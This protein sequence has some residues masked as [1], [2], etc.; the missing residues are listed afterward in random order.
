MPHRDTR[1]R[2]YK[3][4]GN[5]SLPAPAKDT[6]LAF[7]VRLAGIDIGTD[8]EL[9]RVCGQ[10]RAR[11]GAHAQITP[12]ECPLPEH[13][14]AGGVEIFTARGLVFFAARLGD[15]V[16]LGRPPITIVVDD[17]ECRDISG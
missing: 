9:L 13:F 16:N 15:E 3:I 7:A 10:Q 4:S 2:S 17:L 14:A 6:P 5:F 12:L 11:F 1:I 8:M